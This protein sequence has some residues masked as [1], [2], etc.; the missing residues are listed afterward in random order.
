MQTPAFVIMISGFSLS[1]TLMAW[2]ET[3]AASGTQL[4][5]APLPPPE[6]EEHS[7]LHA[8]VRRVE[9]D[10]RRLETARL[11]YVACTRARSRL[12]LFASVGWKD[13]EDAPASPRADSL[14]S[15]LWPV[16][17]GHFQQ[18][19]P[20]VENVAQ[21]IPGQALT[22]VRL[23][24]GWSLPQPPAGVAATRSGVEEA[25][26]VEFSWAGETAR[27]AGVAA[28]GV[29]RHI[30]EEGPEAWDA[31]RIGRLAARLGQALAALGVPAEELDSARA[32]VV[33]AVTRTLGDPRGR[34]LLEPGHHEARSEYGLTGLV[35]GVLVS[36]VLDRTF[37]DGE[38]VRW[39]IDYKTGSHG[40]GALE[41]F[42][43]RE[44]ERYR[45]QLQR[46]AALMARMDSRPVRLALYFP[47][48]SA[49][50]EW[51]W[52]GGE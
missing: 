18:L 33:D 40:G 35:D 22:V 2:S 47:A 3:A 12:H 11:L 23:P 44:Q 28:H 6:G 46:Y 34:W 7:P 10:K 42:L 26:A 41:E 15:H 32:A 43:D 19:A 37:V 1:R 20:P 39:I 31:A 27:K 24:S 50:R 16:V 9:R 29:L 25:A 8:F 21:E 17:S 51:A 30:S 14:L 48:L 49:W 45:D 5:L 4:L 36:A 38:G 52:S 13:K